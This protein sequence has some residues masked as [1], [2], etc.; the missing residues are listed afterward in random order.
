MSE[1]LFL[2]C[3]WGPRLES[4][5]AC[6]DSIA[7]FWALSVDLHPCFST[8]LATASKKMKGWSPSVAA[9]IGKLLKTNNLDSTGEPIPEL[10]FNVALWNKCLTFSASIGM[11]HPKM[12]NS[13]VLSFKGESP[14]NPE[15]W[16][17]LVRNAVACFDPD[18]V[19]V[20][21]HSYVEDHGGS[22]PE[23]GGWLTY[24]RGG[25]VFEHTFP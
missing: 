17:A 21:T 6:A 20:T 1:N 16:R 15:F 22:L 5:L 3:Y 8:S 4:K 12:T 19:V 10:G 7:R 23:A 2:A 13:I 14:Y 11:Y 24:Q 9:D 18:H 25:T